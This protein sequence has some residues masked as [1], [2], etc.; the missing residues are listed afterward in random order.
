M[1]V[2]LAAERIVLCGIERPP[3][4]VGG[5]GRCPPRREHSRANRD[6]RAAETSPTA[7]CGR[8]GRRRRTGCAATAASDCTK[9][10]PDAARA[11]A[12]TRSCGARGRASGGSAGSGA[13][14]ALPLRRGAGSRELPG[15]G[16]T[17]RRRGRQR[18]QLRQ[19]PLLRPARSGHGEIAPGVREGAVAAAPAPLAA[20][21]GCPYK[22][23]E[24]PGGACRG[25]S[26]ALY[27]TRHTG[28]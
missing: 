7:R 10:H 18:M 2:V 12:G 25:G 17:G 9:P 4:S 28:L 1:E 3:A 14:G 27:I 15:A 5:R 26:Y 8:S 6:R 11:V 24:P 16:R 22:G 20:D 23:A 13:G 19:G 21:H